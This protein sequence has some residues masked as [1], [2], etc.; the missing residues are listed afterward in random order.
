MSIDK[1][2]IICGESL[3]EEEITDLNKG[4]AFV[5]ELAEM[6]SVVVESSVSDG[7]STAVKVTD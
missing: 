6:H 1:S 7:T 5:R 3:G 4:R 2:T